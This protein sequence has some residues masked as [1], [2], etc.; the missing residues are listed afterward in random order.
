MK[1]VDFNNLKQYDTLLKEYIDKEIAAAIEI[2]RQEDA[3]DDNIIDDQS[4][5]D[6]FVINE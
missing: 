4:G 2:Y 3:E 6:E 1:F 5:E